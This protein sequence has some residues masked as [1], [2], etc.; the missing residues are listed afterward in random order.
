M[1]WTRIELLV[2]GLLRRYRFAARKLDSRQGR[3]PQDKNVGSHSTAT[4]SRA[5]PATAG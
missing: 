3:G 5:F 4:G 1:V 2:L